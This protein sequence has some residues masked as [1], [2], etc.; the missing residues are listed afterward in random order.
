MDKHSKSIFK[1]GGVASILMTVAFIWIGIA[2]MLDPVER[3]RGEEF[4]VM[5]AQQPTIQLSWRMAFF[6]VGILALAVIPAVTRWVRA[7]DGYGEGLLHWTSLLAYI[8]S[9]SVAIDSMRGVFLV[10]DNLIEAYATGDKMY[11]MAAKMALIG[12]TDAQGVFQYGGVGLWYIVVGIMALKTGKLPKVLSCFII[13]GGIGYLST[14]LFGQTD[15]FI[16][17]TEIA[18]QAIAALVA[19]ALISPVLHTW[20]GLILFRTG[21]SK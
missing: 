12:S 17:G 8:G 14:L 21:N 13:A 9:A 7:E 6:F 1:W 4:W 20:L 18:A 3:Y 11:Q 10:R 15:T 2:M 16:P 19:G 5:A